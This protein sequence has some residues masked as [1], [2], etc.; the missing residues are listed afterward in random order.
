MLDPVALATKFVHLDGKVDDDDF[1]RFFLAMETWLED[2]VAFPGR[3]FIDWVQLYRTDALAR[4]ELTLEGH[5]IDLRRVRCP[6][7]VIVAEGDYITP[8]ASSLPLPGLVGTGEV[9]TVRMSGGHIGLS[10]GRAA[11][12]R[13]W[14]AVSQWL[15]EREHDAN[16]PRR[17]ATAP[18]RDA[19]A[20][21]PRE[22]MPVAARKLAR[23]GPGHGK[24]KR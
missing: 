16:A 13:L 21:Q 24:R 12:E 22:K 14:P 10:T 20:P 4:G 7:F 23:P 5:P 11:H 2:S 6:I 15:H 1:V 3:A 18:Q 9:K 17:D 8:P 19:S